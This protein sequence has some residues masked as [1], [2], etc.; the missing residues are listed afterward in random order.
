MKN[1]IIGLSGG[2]LI[3][4]GE[5]FLG[6][7]RAYVNNDYIESVVRAGG[8]PVVLPVILNEELIKRQVE[9]VD[10]VIITGGYDVNPLV[11]GEEPSQSQGFTYPEMDE[12]DLML[13]KIACE[14][15]KPI[16]GICRGLQ[17][18]NVAFGGTLYQ[19]LAQIEGC[20]I[21]HVQSSKGD[22][23]G[24]SIEVKKDT[25]LYNIFGEAALVNSFHHQAIKKLAPGFTVSANSKDGVIEA[26]EKNEGN[27]IVG[28]QWHPEMM[29][30]DNVNML[31]IFKKLVEKAEE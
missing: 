26:I 10:G 31:D 18:L 11:Y 21:K 24:H 23:A 27:F 4:E 1:P 12:Y 28:V 3:I 19:D 8:S 29:T 5:T 14:L 22:F 30:G 15:K 25:L 16:L 9:A 7:E 20:Y 13:I 2:L 6:R 17:I